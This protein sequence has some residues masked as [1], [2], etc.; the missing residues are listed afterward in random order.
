MDWLDLL[1]NASVG[2]TLGLPLWALAAIA[3]RVAC[4]WAGLEIPALGRAMMIV[5]AILAPTLFIGWLFQVLFF[6]L[7]GSSFHP[8]LQFL[9]FAITLIAHATISLAIYSQVLHARL[10]QAITIWL[11]STLLFLLAVACFAC[12]VW[13]PTHFIRREQ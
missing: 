13:V 11:V 12:V 3:L 10:G 7:D 9:V 4:H 2:C 5:L 8:A 1:W 6:G